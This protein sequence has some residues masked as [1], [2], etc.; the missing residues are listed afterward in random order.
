MDD[1]KIVELYLSRNED[2]I[3]QTAQK[4]GSSAGYRHF[5][6]LWKYKQR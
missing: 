3:V 4:Y 2:A 1:D 6:K 5:K